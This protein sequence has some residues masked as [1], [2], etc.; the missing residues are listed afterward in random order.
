M[1]ISTSFTAFET[2]ASR[3]KCQ[4][5][6]RHAASFLLI[7]NHCLLIQGLTCRAPRAPIQSVCH[8]II[9]SSNPHRLSYAPTCD[10]ASTAGRY[11]AEAADAAAAVLAWVGPGQFGPPRHRT[12]FQSSYP[13]SVRETL[14]LV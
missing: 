2:H 5:F 8:V 9:F 7:A 12:R 13:E 14:S 4:S 11:A 10:V 6:L 3:V 1:V